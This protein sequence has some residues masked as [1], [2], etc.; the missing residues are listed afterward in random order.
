MATTP[1]LLGDRYEVGR[2]LGA[3]G[4]AEVFEGRDRLLAR[5]VAI[6]VL[7]AEFARDPAFLVRF[8]REAQAAASLSHPNIVAVYDTGVEQGTNFIVMEFVEGRTLRDLLRIGG[9]PPAERAAAIASDICDAL[10]AAHARGIIHRD[11]KPGN[12]MLTADGV[13][14]VMDFGIA[15]A[16]T[17]EPITQ[18]AAVVGTAQYISPEQVQ[19]GQVDARSD[20][21]SLGCVLYELLTGRPP[22]SGESPVAIAYRHVR[23]DPTPPRRVD[24]RVPAA[25]EA[26]TLRAMAKDPADRYQTAVEMR[27]DLERALAGQPVAAVA[28]A[29]IGAGA[30]Q[31][32]PRT[33]GYQPDT[34]PGGLPPAGYPD[35]PPRRSRRAAV[36][37]ALLAVLLAVAAFAVVAMNTR[38]RPTTQGAVTTLPTTLVPTTPPTTTGAPSTSRETTTTRQPTT[39]TRQQ[40]TT[41]A[42]QETTTTQGRALVPD[43]L[44]RREEVAK[45]LLENR[46][47]QVDSQEVQIQDR[48]LDGRVV[49]QDPRP[50][51]PVPS[52]ST[53]NIFIGHAA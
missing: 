34:G 23:D 9:P 5:R 49:D 36:L 18:T 12:M 32:M 6:K 15:R 47:F 50:S 25:F 51:T 19:G 39:T 43:V 4:M 29:G 45:Q 1:L 40:T 14:K 10:A 41:T 44:G 30:T 13:V 22:F 17:S 42:R 21:Y 8:K 46:G 26:I 11:V 16:T 28:P 2:L 27:A 48:R 37:L 35:A 52:G 7:L 24:P 3:G 33:S 53:V 38:G 31:A 20:L